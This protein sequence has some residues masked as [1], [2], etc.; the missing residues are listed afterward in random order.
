MLRINQGP[1]MVLAASPGGRFW[2]K[3]D[4]MGR[5]AAMDLK[6]EGEPRLTRIDDNEAQGVCQAATSGTQWSVVRYRG[7]LQNIAPLPPTPVD[8]AP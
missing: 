1:E 6:C 4:G 2:K 8:D 3:P 7:E 5:E